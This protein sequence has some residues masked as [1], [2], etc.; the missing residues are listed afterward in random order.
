MKTLSGPLGAALGLALFAAGCAEGGAGGREV[1]I[2]QTDEGCVPTS[3]EASPGEKLQFVVKNDSGH[4]VYELEGIEG[5]KLEEFVI[6]KGKTRKSGYTVP[7]EG[8][9]FKMKCYVPAGPSTIIDVV[10][11]DGTSEIAGDDETATRSGGPSDDVV[12]VTLVEYAVQPDKDT[13]ATG[14]IRFVASNTSASQV[15]ELAVLRRNQNGQLENE[16]E[17][18]DIDPGAGGELVLELEPGE[19]ELACLIAPGEAG[20]TVD[21]YEQGMHIAF[22]VTE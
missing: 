11:G 19:Y 17:I 13:V 1:N 2:T 20:S 8:G 16:G 4:D 9:T 14:A 15:H 10:A 21:H 7:D 6:P 12:A 5:T 18:E 22:T 3:V